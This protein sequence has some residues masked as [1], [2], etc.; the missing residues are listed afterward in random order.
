MKCRLVVHDEVNV[1][2]KNLKDRDL[3][4]IIKDTS[5]F[6]KGAHMSAEYKIGAWDGKES[7]VDENG[8]TL[9]FML[10]EILP[11]IEDMG[12]EIDLE[13]HRQQLPEPPEPITD[14]IFE[15]HGINLR[16]YQTDA[17][18][19][20]V[21]NE[22]GVLSVATSGGKTLIT[23]AIAKV[24]EDHYRSIVIVP[25]ENLV[26][27]TVAEMTGVGLDTG[28]IYGK[29][30]KK[31]REKEW[32]KTHVVTTWQTLKNNRD[33]LH[34]FN[35]VIFDECHECGDV[36]F[37]L[38]RFDLA[39]API[40]V[41]LTGTVPKDKHKRNKIMAHLGGDVLL[42]I[43]GRQLMDEG[44]I[45]KVDIHIHGIDQEV[46]VPE[47]GWDWD[48]EYRH[49]MTD[50]VRMMAIADFINQLPSQNTLILTHAKFGKILAE[51]LEKDFIDQEVDASV[52]EQ[53]YRKFDDPDD[54]YLVASYGT[55]GTGI[56]INDIYQVVM[57]DVGKDYTKA[58][59]GIGRGCRLDSK[60]IHKVTIYDL[61]SILPISS[62]HYKERIKT[63]RNEKYPHSVG[64]KITV[65]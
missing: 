2:L 12:Y 63:Y 9:F 28:M 49:I 19:A 4:R 52:R 17:V 54:Y 29:I 56:S 31:R 21:E 7:L 8:M 65:Q 23:S 25:S 6:V 42:K 40:R 10:D 43:G 61:Y 36:M 1:E 38:L 32:K 58:I 41:G 53:Y 26:K 51:Y 48:D 24:Y 64:D 44:H 45:S 30:T 33:Q 35:V 62:K 59:Q 39:H 60:G 20:V 57:I 47:D 18:N 27:Q 34:N 14:G 46:H 50:P 3:N 55:V 16:Y 37:D 15:D 13:D 22:K 11:M 5:I